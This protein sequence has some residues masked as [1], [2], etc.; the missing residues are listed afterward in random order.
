MALLEF[1]GSGRSVIYSY[2][3]LT[4]INQPEL[5]LVIPDQVKTPE[6]KN[7][8]GFVSNLQR[9]LFEETTPQNTCKRKSGA[10]AEA[11]NSL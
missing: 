4:P 10:S 11:I 6:L 2:K 1:R 9:T 3:L 8:G 7:G 5:H